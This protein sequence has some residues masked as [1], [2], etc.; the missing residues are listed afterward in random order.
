MEKVLE[1]QGERLILK[2]GDPF[3]FDGQ[4]IKEIDMEGLANLTAADM[5]AIDQLM[6]ARGYS[7]TR[8]DASRQYAMFVAARV[9]NKP[10]EFCDQMKARDAIRLRDMVAA[11]FT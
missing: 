8:M 6:L 5:C 4:E 9:N 3:M 10:Y 11:F 7:G 2:L 1:K